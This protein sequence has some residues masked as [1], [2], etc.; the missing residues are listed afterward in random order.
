MDWRT[1]TAGTKALLVLVIVMG[2]LILLGTTALV[3]VVAHRLTHPA[4]HAGPPAVVP[5]RPQPVAAL[6]APAQDG[7][8]IVSVTRQSDTLLDILLTG[9]GPD[10]VLVWNL[11]TGRP[12]AEI[13]PGR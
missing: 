2:V 13:K 8:R 10:R 9:G 6:P 3:V 5:G 7:T 12:A 4:V 1:M 11:T